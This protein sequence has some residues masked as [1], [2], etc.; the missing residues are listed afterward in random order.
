MNDKFIM[1]KKGIIIDLPRVCENL[2]QNRKSKGMTQIEFAGGYDERVLRRFEHCEIKTVEPVKQFCIDNK[3]D[4]SD[5]I[6]GCTY[7]IVRD[8]D[9]LPVLVPI[10]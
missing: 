5:I 2:K 3:I 9:G 10:E 6:S 8:R 1:D 7:R 4:F